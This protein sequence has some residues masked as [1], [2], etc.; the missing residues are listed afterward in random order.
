MTKDRIPEMLR[1]HAPDITD[2]EAAAIYWSVMT[3]WRDDY[4][5]ETTFHRSSQLQRLTNDLVR[6]RS[7]SNPPW[8]AIGRHEEIIA[9]ITGTFAE[10]RVTIVDAPAQIKEALVSVI[11]GMSEDEMQEFLEAEGVEVV[12]S[13]S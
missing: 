6:M 2:R 9:R 5:R 8:G 11:S 13:G 7:A 12:D 10:Q 1:A 4:S 3:Q